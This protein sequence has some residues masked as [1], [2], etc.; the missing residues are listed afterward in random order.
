MKRSAVAAWSG[1]AVAAGFTTWLLIVNRSPT[2]KPVRPTSASPVPDY[3]ISEAVVT[4][5]DEQGA[6][7]YVL[8]AATIA[9]L[10]ASG[11]STLSR[12]TLDYYA[13]SGAT[14]RLTALQGRLAANGNDLMLGGDVHARQLAQNDPLQFTAPEAEVGLDSRTVKSSARV[15]LWQASYRLAGTGLDAD[16]RSGIV[17]LLSDV[18]GRY[19]R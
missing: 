13:P 15:Q 10:P 5:F 17:K 6:P 2:P 18:T 8:D 9:H 12:I 7:Q 3:T 1:L 4:S 11:V 16:L 14:W 19:E